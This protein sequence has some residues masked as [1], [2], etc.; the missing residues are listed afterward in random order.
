MHSTLFKSMKWFHHVTVTYYLPFFVL[1][2]VFYYFINIPAVVQF[3]ALKPSLELWLS[4]GFY[5]YAI[6]PVEVLFMMLGLAPFFFL[7]K[8]KRYLSFNR[9]E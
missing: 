5:R 7:I 6:P 8:S 2:F 3:E 1:T 9:E 4:L